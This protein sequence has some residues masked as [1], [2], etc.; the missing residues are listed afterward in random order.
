MNA[1]MYLQKVKMDILKKK[2]VK[3]PLWNVLFQYLII[4]SFLNNV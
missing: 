1:E 3:C 4:C 2:L